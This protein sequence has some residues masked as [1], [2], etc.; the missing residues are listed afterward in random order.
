M[1]TCFAIV[2]IPLAL[3]GSGCKGPCGQG[4][5]K[6]DEPKGAFAD[7]GYPEGTVACLSDDQ[8]DP[9]VAYP[10]GTEE[11]AVKRFTAHM[12]AKG[13]ESLPISAELQKEQFDM[14]V[15]GSSVGT[16][17]LF[18]KKGSTKRY[19]AEIEGVSAG[20]VVVPLHAIDCEPGKSH[21][22]ADVYCK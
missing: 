7:V 8:D 12:V 21:G 1:K 17:V 16:L 6:T 18:G 2:T 11:D 19:Y 3:A 5:T 10:E 13:F 22:V 9:R 15:A 14:A 4:L 20:D